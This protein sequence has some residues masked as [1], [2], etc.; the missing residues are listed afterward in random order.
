MKNFLYSGIMLLLIQAAYTTTQCINNSPE[1]N[2]NMLLYNMSKPVQS[3][4]NNINTHNPAHLAA[5]IAPSTLGLTIVIGVLSCIGCWYSLLRCWRIHH[6]Q[7]VV[8]DEFVPEARMPPP[9]PIS[10]MRI[11]AQPQNPLGNIDERV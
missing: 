7:D 4:E 1:I 9:L 3:T 2:S 6:V 5:E 8:F 10:L 11:H